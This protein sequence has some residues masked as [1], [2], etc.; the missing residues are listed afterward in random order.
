MP[1]A[2]IELSH[3][4]ESLSILDAD[5]KVDRALEPKLDRE[6][7]L[8]LW[9]GLLLARRFD[10]RLLRLQRQGRIGTFGPGMGQEA[11]S[12]GPA[13][14]MRKNDW[15][16]PSFRESAA[17]LHRGWPLE[18]IIL[19]WAGHEEGATVP[20]GMNDLPICVPV[21]SQC[22]HAAG[23]AWAS[24][25][26]GE[27]AVAVVFLGDG[28][29]SEGDFHEAMNF[30]CVHSLPMICVIQNNHWAISLPR[31]KQSKSGTLAQK[32]L[33]YGCRGI[34]IDGNDILAMVAGMREAIEQ[35]RA[36]GGPTLVE[37]VTYRLG[38]HTT[39]DDPKKYRTDEEVACWQPRDPLIRFEKY[40]RGRGL[41]DDDTQA[42]LE[43]EITEQIQS[44]VARAEAYRPDPM[45]SFENTFA[46]MPPSL[47]EQAD[48]FRAYMD[49]LEA[50]ER[51][52]VRPQRQLADA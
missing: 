32:C 42:R 36:G 5:G 52:A 26:R 19:W 11:A 25:L 13:F 45:R 16:V 27:D 50:A 23:I 10:E 18:K 51:P 43:T 9:R 39:A 17:M 31:A 12:L 48:E 47:A 4:V 14:V 44:A 8:A 28:G 15:F 35:A 40:L 1:R 6:E 30:A 49:A 41:L 21:A 46:E 29:T 33:A 38:V 20:V 24:K 34:Q 7:L 37:A 22:L 3:P 2:P